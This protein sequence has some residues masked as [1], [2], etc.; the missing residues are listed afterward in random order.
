VT[1]E[2][3]ANCDPKVPCVNLTPEGSIHL[4]FRNAYE[5]VRRIYAKD[6]GETIPEQTLRR[7]LFICGHSLGGALGL[8]HAA[9]LKDR[10]PILY[11]YGMPRT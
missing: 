1:P 2:V 4:G 3:A 7:K 11:T 9:A 5:V 8:V 6:L 10:N